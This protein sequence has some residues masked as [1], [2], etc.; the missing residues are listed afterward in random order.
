MKFICTRE[1]VSAA[2]D[3]EF[4]VEAE[5]EEEAIELFKA[6]KGEPSAD[7]SEVT[8]LGEYDLSC[9]WAG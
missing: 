7:N 6:G 3:Q 5:T 2:G 4:S 9:V 1:V 8:E